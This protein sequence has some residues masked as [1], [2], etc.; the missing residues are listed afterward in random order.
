MNNVAKI[1]LIE[2][3]RVNILAHPNMIG[4]LSISTRENSPYKQ[5]KEIKVHW[6]QIAILAYRSN[7]MR[8]YF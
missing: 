8:T 4:H 1:P 5:K 6:K 7:D 3:G 2:D